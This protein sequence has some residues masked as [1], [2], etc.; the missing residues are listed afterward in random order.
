MKCKNVAQ[1]QKRGRARKLK[2][3]EPPMETERNELNA[4]HRSNHNLISLLPPPLLVPSPVCKLKHKPTHTATLNT[5][6]STTIPPGSQKSRIDRTY[7]RI[8][9]IHWIHW[10]VESGFASRFHPNQKS[11]ILFIF[12]P[13]VLSFLR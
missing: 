1:K 10:P 8:T 13:V 4:T 6:T 9:R 12:L 5:P 11:E 7:M 2:F 3:S